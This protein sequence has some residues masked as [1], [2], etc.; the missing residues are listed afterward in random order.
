MDDLIGWLR[1]QLDEDERVA[2]EAN[3]APWRRITDKHWLDPNTIFGGSYMGDQEKLRNVASLEIS[4]VKEGNA[5]HITRWDPAR[6]LAEVEAKRDL[7]GHVE[8]LILYATSPN[9]AHGGIEAWANRAICLL[10]QPYA[11]RPGWQEEWRA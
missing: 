10:A 11:E 1:A 2:R 8:G 6:V 5:E 3:P 4:W 7:L 9:Y